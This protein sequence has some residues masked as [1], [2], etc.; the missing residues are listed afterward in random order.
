MPRHRA[1]GYLTKLVYRLQL[2][3]RRI[4]DPTCHDAIVRIWGIPMQVMETL[5]GWSLGILDTEEAPIASLN[6][7]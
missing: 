2:V 1:L 5:E 3:W 4:G 6:D 7:P